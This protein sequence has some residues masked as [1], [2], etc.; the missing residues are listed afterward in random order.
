MKTM[1][2]T[3]EVSYNPMEKGAWE[4]K[5]ASGHSLCQRNTD[6][7]LGKRVANLWSRTKVT[8]KAHAGRRQESKLEMSIKII[9]P[10]QM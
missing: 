3:E 9:W 8:K 4:P 1:E 10:N 6:G 7:G 2:K 5:M